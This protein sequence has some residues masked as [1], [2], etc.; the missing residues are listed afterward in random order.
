MKFYAVPEQ[1]VN[2]VLQYLGS[3]PYIEVAQLIGALGQIQEVPPAPLA[4]VKENKG[5]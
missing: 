4:V 2:A 1:L 5:E 3:K